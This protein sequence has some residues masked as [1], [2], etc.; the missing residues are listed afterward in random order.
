MTAPRAFSDDKPAA[1]IRI[2]QIGTAH[3]HAAGKME[4]VRSLRAVLKTQPPVVVITADH[5]AEVQR[6]VRAQGYAL[7]R[8]PLKAAVLDRAW[9]NISLTPDP[10]AASLQTSADNAAAAGLTPEA[11]LKGIYD[12]RLLNGLLVASGKSPVSADGLG[13][14]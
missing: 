7:L 13:P 11:D 8:K 14:E 5:S 4:A 3:S 12:L 9:A 6:A 2:G 10:I 1:K